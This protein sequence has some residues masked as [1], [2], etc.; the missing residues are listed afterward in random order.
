[1]DMVSNSTQPPMPLEILT[2][3]LASQNILKDAGRTA[4]LARL[5]DR[6]TPPHCFRDMPNW[7]VVVDGGLNEGIASEEE[8]KR[9]NS[10]RSFKQLSEV[11]GL[12]RQSEQEHSCFQHVPF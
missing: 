2:A 5:R 6:Q 10:G 9:P 12:N 8:P 11:H 4:T 3:F 7:S 1:M